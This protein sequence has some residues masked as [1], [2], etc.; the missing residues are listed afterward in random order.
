MNHRF[1]SFAGLFTFYLLI[2]ALTPA[3]LAQQLQSGRG[4]KQELEKHQRDTSRGCG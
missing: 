1:G 4:L 3:L 2:V